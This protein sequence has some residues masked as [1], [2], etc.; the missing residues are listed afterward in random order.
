MTLLRYYKPINA[1]INKN[2]NKNTPNEKDKSLFE[3]D[4]NDLSLSEISFSESSTEEEIDEPTRNSNLF[5]QERKTSKYRISKRKIKAKINKKGFQRKWLKEFSW[6]R[7]DSKEKKMH[8]E[9][10]RFHGINIPFAKEG[11]KN[12]GK[13][14]AIQEHNNSSGHKE[15]LK[16]KVVDLQ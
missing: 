9:L 10:C 3:S 5:S 15:A 8:C 6:L 12:I 14:S 1:N 11:S 4:E 16:K 2:K 13:K 7:Y